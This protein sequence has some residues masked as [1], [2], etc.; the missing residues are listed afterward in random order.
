MVHA[1]DALLALAAQLQPA[2]LRVEDE[3]KAR[4]GEL[5]R[6][7]PAYMEALIAYREKQGQAVYPDANATLRVSYG[8]VSPLKARDAV[9]YE[10]L[11]TTAGIVEKNTGVAPFDAPKP[12]LEAIAK[13]DYAG[14][15][16][17]RTGAMPVDFL[18]NL[19]TTGGNSG[20]PVLNARGELVGLNFDSNWEAVSASWMFD[21]RY[22]RAIHVDLRYMRW[23]MDKVY[24]APAL[25][26][27][28]GVPASEHR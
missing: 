28:L 22:K 11:T 24:P 19:D 20:S 13:A 26:K 25:L 2:L 16:D 17:G 21:P 1:E 7:R 3:R 14:Y 6:L 5:L 18:S 12:L 15:A 10:A 4:E 23:L 27:E 9:S 8:K